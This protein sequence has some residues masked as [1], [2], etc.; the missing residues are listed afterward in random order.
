MGSIQRLRAESERDSCSVRAV[1]LQDDDQRNQSVHNVAILPSKMSVL[2]CAR[3]LAMCSCAAFHADV[4]RFVACCVG[5]PPAA[6]GPQFLD[7]RR[8]AYCIC[9]CCAIEQNDDER[10]V[11]TV[12]F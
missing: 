11:F 8:F 6:R 1:K 7:S 10:R 5:L 9:C 2:L 3:R 4:L 12:T